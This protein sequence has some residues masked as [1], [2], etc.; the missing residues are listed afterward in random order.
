[1]F[2]TNLPNRH[3]MIPKRLRQPR[4]ARVAGDHIGDQVGEVRLVRVRELPSVQIQE[5]IRCSESAAFVAL[6]EGVVAS[7]ADEQGYGE[8]HCVGLTIVPIVQ[9]AR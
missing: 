7:D 4:F 9:R 2:L 8:H 5:V 1:M 6:Q 3:N